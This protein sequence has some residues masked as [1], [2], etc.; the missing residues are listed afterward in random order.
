MEILILSMTAN[1]SHTGLYFGIFF[2]LNLSLWGRREGDGVTYKDLLIKW[3]LKRLGPPD[4]GPSGR[5]LK[6]LSARLDRPESDRGGIGLD[7]TFIHDAL[8]VFNFLFHK[9]NSR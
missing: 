4:K 5:E 9:I 7:Y 3:P 1:S 6:G 2:I 8:N